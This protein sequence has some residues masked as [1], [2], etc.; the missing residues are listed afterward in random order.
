MKIPKNCK[1]EAVAS[2]DASRP[3]LH[4]PYLEVKDGRGTLV[5]TNGRSLVAL[6]VEVTE[7]DVD[8]WVSIPAIV[9]GRKWA[10]KRDTVEIACNGS[11]TLPDGV[12]FPRPLATP[13][14]APADYIP[15][16]FPNWR[17]VVPDKDRKTVL[18]VSF[19]PTLLMGL[20]NALGSGE[21]ITLEFEDELNTIRVTGKGEGFGVLM[22][23]RTM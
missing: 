4:A 8:G 1:I 12:S 13:A 18:K 3:V 22:P 19:N 11:C 17:Q 6:P 16:R 14:D 2:T 10:G 23:M 15:S 7:H 5:A 21:Q 20:A 9:A